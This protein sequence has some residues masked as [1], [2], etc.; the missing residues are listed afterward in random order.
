[1]MTANRPEPPEGLDK[2]SVMGINWGGTGTGFDDALLASEMSVTGDDLFKK[3]PNTYIVVTEKAPPFLKKGLEDAVEE[4]GF[5][6][7]RGK[8]SP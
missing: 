8:W 3:T 4:A 7:I 1:M 5:H 2:T 6:L